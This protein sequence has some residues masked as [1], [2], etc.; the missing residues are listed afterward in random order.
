MRLP[1]DLIVF[2]LETNGAS[3]EAPNDHRIVEIGAVRLDADLR[4]VDEFSML[5]DGR[6][7]LPAVVKI[8][9]ITDQ[10]LEGKPKF[11]EMHS[12]F[13][14]WCGKRQEYVFGAWGAYFDIPVLR[15]E[16]TRAGRK[17]PHRGESFDVKAA[18]WW[19]LLSKGKPAKRLGLEQAAGLYGIPFFGKQHKAVDDA[20]MTVRVLQAIA[21]KPH[22][23]I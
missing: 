5:V 19:D 20:R 8:H 6:P 12:E 10:D 21:G 17:Y 11:V 22:L 4:I 16:Y 3:E 18:V 1:F 13:D 23:S 7:V 14:A 2:D 15:A 9:G